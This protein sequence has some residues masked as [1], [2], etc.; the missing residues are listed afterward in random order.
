[1]TAQ[2]D[3]ALATLRELVEPLARP[4][5]PCGPILVRLLRPPR[6]A[7]VRGGLHSENALVHRASQDVDRSQSELVTSGIAARAVVFS[8]HPGDDLARLAESEEI[9]LLLVDG[10]RP[11]LGDPVPLVDIKPVLERA[12]CDVDILVAREG[13]RIGL[14]PGAPILVPFGGVEHDWSA[15]ELG[16][17][18][19]S[20]PARR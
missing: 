2:A 9:D 18:L 1:M 3:A 17:W 14:G 7:G 19:A 4:E 13:G 8:A 15:L 16:K 20:A 12:P 10:Q 5:P 11:L 6:G